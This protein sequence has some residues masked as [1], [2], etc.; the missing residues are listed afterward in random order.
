MKLSTFMRGPVSKNDL[1]IWALNALSICA[2]LCLMAFS[3]C[4][5]NRNPPVIHYGLT[6]GEV[7]I[8]SAIEASA[9]H[10]VAYLVAPTG[11]M[12]PFISG[13]DI[14][15]V[16][17][18][19]PFSAIEVGYMLTYQA[20][21]LPRSNPPVIHWAAQKQGNSWIMDGQN[22]SHYENEPNQLM[23]QEDFEFKDKNGIRVGGKVVSV[24][25]ERTK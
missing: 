25:T 2:L 24:Y 9:I 23:R 13:G 7:A 18:K 5:P 21:W 16:D 20:Q 4:T 11:S 15:V 12:E 3:S 22:N 14:V 6:A 8:Q 10:G 17:N 1:L 19:F